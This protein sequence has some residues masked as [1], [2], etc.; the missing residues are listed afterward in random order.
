MIRSWR[1]SLAI[2]VFILALLIRLPGLGKFM[3]VDEENWML[4]SANFYD[5]LVQG[6][7]GGTFLTTHPGSTAMWL[8]GSGILLQELKLGLRIDTTNTIHFHRAAVIP[9]TIVISA[10]IGLLVWLLVPL[11]GTAPAVSAGIFVAADTYLIGSSQI[12][13]LD[14]LQALLMITS[15]AA[16]LLT[17][18]GKRK[19]FYA[20]LSGVL[21]GLAL[22]V[23]LFLAAWLIPVMTAILIIRHYQHL[24]DWSE[25]IRLMSYI[26]GIAVLIFFVLWPALWVKDDISRSLTRDFSNVVTQEHVSLSTSSNPISPSSFYLRTWLGRTSVYVQIIT[27]ITILLGILIVLPGVMGKKLKSTLEH[28][29]NAK[30]ITM[31]LWFLLYGCGFLILIT[32]AAKKGDR[33]ALPGLVVFPMIAG[34]VYVYI[35]KYL[36]NRFSW[37]SRYVITINAILA[38]VIFVLPWRASPYAIAY[39]NPFWPNVRPLSQQGWGEGLESA[40][41][42]LN[43]QPDA[44]QTIVASWYPSVMRAYFLGRTL[45]L[46]SRDDPRVRYIITYRNMAGRDE[47]SQAADILNEFAAQEPVHTVYIN[48]IPYAKIYSRL[49]VRH[50]TS[51]IG[52]LVGVNEVGQIVQPKTEFWT[53]I[54]IGFSTFSSRINTQDIIVNI[55]DG[56]DATVPLRTVRAN[57]RDIV[58]NEWHRFNFAE[59][60]NAASREFYVSIT[61][62]TSS[63]GDAITVRYSSVD[64][65]PGKMVWIQRT[66]REGENRRDFIQMGDIAYR[67]PEE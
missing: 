48:N 54:D 22:G 21:F 67:I 1:E 57:A 44:A 66:L 63:V 61:S 12:G 3:T 8:M 25:I 45:S 43:D 38:L 14:A 31:M 13:H 58:D 40:A 15:L 59:I 56:V 60:P 47:E 27:L 16:F 50:F 42:W 65:V 19:F 62:P 28:I 51:H 30:T 4:R 34:L 55:F 23:K 36:R 52:D 35:L 2:M 33:Y 29:I 7:P 46:S 49:N 5:E 6:N 53:G 41:A 20:A 37:N 18:Q 17:C 10:L 26:S 9:V 32:F 39:N 24:I 64:Y 11:F